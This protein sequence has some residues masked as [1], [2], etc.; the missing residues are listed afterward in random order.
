MAQKR[1][2]LS[3]LAVSVYGEDTR[4]CAPES[5]HSSPDSRPST[6]DSTSSNSCVS[7]SSAS[8]SS[9][10]TS[11]SFESCDNGETK[12][13]FYKSAHWTND[14][15]TIITASYDNKICSF[16][17][18]ENLLEPRDQPLNLRPYRTLQLAT[19]TNVVA[20]APYYDI[21]I[22]NTDHLLVAS[23]DHPIQ[24]YQLFPPDRTFPE[25]GDAPSQ[26]GMPYGPPIA[27]YHFASPTTENY[28]PVH[29]LVW[30]KP[31]THF[32]VGTRDLIA[33]FDIT[34][35]GDGPSALVPTI[36]SRRHIRK[37]NG[38]G[39]RGTVSALSTQPT[40][41]QE[42]TGL[43]AAGTWT[44]WVGLYDIARSGECAAVWNIQ[45]AAEGVVHTDTPTSA[46]LS[47][48]LTKRTSTKGAVLPI[49]GIGGA[50]IN[51]T[52]WS[53]CGRYL[54]VN[55][56]QSTG[57]LVYDVRGANRVLGFLAGRDA[58]THQRMSCDVFNGLQSVGG[59]EVW[60]GAMDGTV[61][62]WEGVGNTE[63]CQWPSW[64]FSA[65]DGAAG[66]QGIA[67]PAL[68]SV[69]LHY[70]GSVVAT[71]AGSWT[72]DADDTSRDWTESGCGETDDRSAVLPLTQCPGQPLSHAPKT[73]IEKS[74]LK[75]WSIGSSSPSH[76]AEIA[77]ENQLA[78]MLA[79]EEEE[80]EKHRARILSTL[81]ITEENDSKAMN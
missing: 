42:A 51:Q 6:A 9:N 74:S 15:T 2:E 59:F 35:N 77:G 73:K 68:G 75:L 22:P 47:S 21:R 23:H 48:T 50:G 72:P 3:L 25:D 71:C 67:S 11:D 64:D 41:D 69:G 54:V 13:Y 56:R 20:T 32:Y 43:I 58:R 66:A 60:A 33:Q 45:E 34:R 31:G 40:A 49:K 16:L 27:S 14:G 29:S 63:G 55:E 76:V 19:P 65:T 79:G 57:M 26:G 5:S 52:A 30:P 18:P 39:M 61:K 62:V 36:P 24:L 53:P 12:A 7:T 8:D 4:P 28:Y 17:V 44:R 1:P 38:I 37:G 80:L 10:E 78:E 70:S 46:G 81:G